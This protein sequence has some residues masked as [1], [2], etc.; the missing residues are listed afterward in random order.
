MQTIPPLPTTSVHCTALF[1]PTRM[2]VRRP[3]NGTPCRAALRSACLANAAPSGAFRCCVSNGTVPPSTARLGDAEMERSVR[4]FWRVSCA[5]TKPSSVRPSGFTSPFFTPDPMKCRTYPGRL[6]T[7][8][9]H[10]I[11]PAGA[12]VPLALALVARLPCR[13][14]K[15][16]NSL[17]KMFLRAGARSPGFRSIAGLASPC[18]RW[19]CSTGSPMDCQST[20][21]A[22]SSACLRVCPHEAFDRTW[23]RDR[24]PQASAM[25]ACGRTAVVVERRLQARAGAAAAGRPERDDDHADGGGWSARMRPGPATASSASDP[26]CGLA[27]GLVN[28]PVD[29][30]NSTSIPLMPARS[31]QRSLI[32]GITPYAVTKRRVGFP[33]MIRACRISA[34]RAERLS[35]SGGLGRRART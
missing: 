17:M 30:S 25:V 34:V 6:L 1:S 8:A 10:C 9:G 26:S 11:F 21:M 28:F 22:G 5:R 32:S 3:I 24:P 14:G 13:E 19:R 31:G 29:A 12:R 2:P 23:S 35:S 16:Q 18:V 33:A 15:S 20:R 4:R 7:L 27:R